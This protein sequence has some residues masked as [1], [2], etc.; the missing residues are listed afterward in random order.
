MSDLP[1]I[2]ERQRNALYRELFPV[3]AESEKNL[4]YFKRRPGSS[5][6][7]IALR[8]SALTEPQVRALNEFRLDQYTL[9][10]FYDLR[11][12]RDHWIE[13]DPDLLELPPDTIHIMVGAGDGRVLAYSYLQPPQG[14]PIDFAS[15]G[16]GPRMGDQERPWFPCE[17]ESLGPDIFSSLPGLRDVPVAQVA[18][19][20][21]LL[22]NQLE[23]GPS[24]LY[25]IAESI[26]A[27]ALI[28]AAP[29]NRLLATVA[30]GGQEA[31]QILYS[32]GMPGLYAPHAPTVHNRL[33]PHWTAISNTPGRFWPCVFSTEDC[34][35]GFEH[36][37]AL[38][39]ILSLSPHELRR[40][41]VD[42]RRAG[43]RIVPRA[44]VPKPGACDIL[45]VTT[46]GLTNPETEHAIGSD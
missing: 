33:P 23:H 32:L 4:L 44:F 12:L 27:T 14:A 43:R 28:Q 37:Q 30:Y 16:H 17:V 19:I 21:I 36:L 20:S 29:S 45:W 22:R 40:G 13:R 15:T 7:T 42:V 1:T 26:L 11:Y 25:A 31:R 5:L 46:P 38:D 24:S 6:V 34:L 3:N 41:L 39:S 2:T 10:G 18:E 8:H 9:C 35:R